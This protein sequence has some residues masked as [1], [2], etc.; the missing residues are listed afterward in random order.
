MAK[1]LRVSVLG[2]FSLVCDGQ[3]IQG[4]GSHKAE[5]LLIY[6]SCTRR[7]YARQVLG[8]FLWPNRPQPQS[9]ANLRRELKVLHDKLDMCIS[10][11][12]DLVELAPDVLLYLD[13]AEFEAQ[14]DGLRDPNR[15]KTATT[16]Y[17]GDFLEGFFI[18]SPAFEAWTR[19]ERERLRYRAIEGLDALVEHSLN[20]GEYAAGINHAMR[21]LQMDSLREKTYH[22]LMLLLARSGD[23]EESLNQ[24]ET[25]RRMLA[26]EF[27][28][29]P[30]A[31]ITALYEQ[32]RDDAPPSP[33]LPPG[34]PRGY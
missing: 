12:R 24:Y 10:V 29:A 3:T 15:L 16:L 23:R 1:L 21:L 28:I 7:P 20:T 22:H 34:W 18:D 13:V 9:L 17:R 6:L 33:P 25:C 30:S 8:E 32:I 5:A 31:E 19:I 4:L 27:N 26:E 14:I 11:N 2:K